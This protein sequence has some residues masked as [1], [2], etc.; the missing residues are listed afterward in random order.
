MT[1]V[2]SPVLPLSGDDEAR[3]TAL[4]RMRALATSLL[5][6]AAIVFALTHGHG[7]AWGYVNATAEAA[8]VGAIADWFAVTALFRHPMGLPIPHTALIPKKKD[9]LAASLQDFVSENFLRE[10]VIRDRIAAAGPAERVGA[11]V[12]APGRVHRIVDEG[13]RVTSDLLG[14]VK[15]ED[16][17]AVITE[18]IIPRMMQ[19]PL[20]PAVGQLLTEIL[21]EGAHAGLVDLGLDELHGW[22]AAH[23]DRIT[24]LI[25]ARAP[26]WAPR[27]ANTMIAD[28]LFREVLTWV[29]DIRD[30]PRH[31]ARV[32]LDHWL[33]ELAHD[34][35]HDADTMERAER[36]KQRLLTQ[37][38]AAVTTVRLWDSFRRGLLE[39]LGDRD[40][41]LRRRIVEEIEGL[42]ERLKSDPVLAAKVDGWAGDAAAYVVEHYGGEIATVISATVERWDGKETS[43]RIELHVG[44]DLQFIRI[45]GTVVGG[46]AGLV[47]HAVSQLW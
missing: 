40:G 16:V 21:D 35:Q 19:E 13:A 20:S 11:W 45:N 29:E 33:V 6:V 32:A 17:Q 46:L 22:L 12:A 26:E 30:D 15:E 24:D 5:V 44:R 37:P 42:G 41:V 38:K 3:R 8:M 47:I 28:R 10:D 14:R 2:M 23:P 31:D 36:L 1:E 27:W 25:I 7:G 4:R 18:L 34:L 43:D 39:A 9:Q